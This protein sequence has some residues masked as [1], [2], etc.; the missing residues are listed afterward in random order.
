MIMAAGLGLYSAAMFHFLTHAFFKALLFLGAG[1]V[2]HALMGEQ[3]IDRM[4]GLRRYLPFAFVAMTVGCLAI[5]GIPPFSGFFSKDE[6]IA[7]AFAAGDLGVVLGIVGLAAAGLTAFYMFRM[8][9]RVFL[10]PEPDGGYRHA[11]HP[12]RWLMS[13]PVAVLAVLA[14]VGGVVEIP[15]VTDWLGEWLAPALTAAPDIEASGTEELVVSVISVVVAL[16]GIGVA[17]WLY[18]ADPGRRLRLA[19]TL[20]GLRRFLGDQWRFDEVYEEAV[21]QPGRD[22]GDAALRGFEPNGAEGLVTAATTVSATG[23]DLV[24][25]SQN[26]LVRV[27]AYA[28]MLGT[29]V[30]AAVIV[31]AR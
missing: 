16:V 27:Y 18:L 19:G 22:L 21:V 20:P 10:G 15:H 2:I 30:V 5:A 24:R 26:G 17:W 9:F 7:Y 1:I 31:L 23:G 13:A 28:L 6:I 14:T 12:S 3:G 4:G 25:R 8:L 11:P 29:V